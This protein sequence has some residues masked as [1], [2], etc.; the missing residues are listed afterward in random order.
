MAAAP[1]CHISDVAEEEGAFLKA[2]Q[3]SRMEHAIEIFYVGL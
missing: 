1:C 3:K 2:L